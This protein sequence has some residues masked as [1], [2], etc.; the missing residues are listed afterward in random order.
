MSIDNVRFENIPPNPED[1]ARLRAECGW[2]E[3]SLKAARR[4]LRGSLI[5]LTCFDG[6]ELV[7]MGRVVGDGALYFYLQD[8]IVKPTHQ[9]RAIGRQIV[10]KLTDEAVARAE[11][12]ATIGLMSAKDKEGF[13]EN[14]GFQVRPTEQLGAGMSR[15]VLSR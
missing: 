11:I 10:S 1:F 7:G 4:A 2:G 14:F 8:I 9:G 3:I 5:D 15:F 12:G 13:Y 6:T